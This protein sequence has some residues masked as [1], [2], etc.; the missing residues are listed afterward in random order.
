[1]ISPKEYE[2]Y[3][4]NLFSNVKSKVSAWFGSRVIGCVFVGILTFVMLW[5]FHLEGALTLALFAAVTN[6]IPIAGPLIAGIAMGIFALIESQPIQAVLILVGFILIQQVEGNILTPLLTKKMV[7]I[8]PVLVIVSLLIGARLWGTLG[9]I[10]VI[11]MA[12]ILYEILREFLMK[13]K[14]DSQN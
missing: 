5:A 6:I 8:P 9:A 2:N 7:G 12:G 11:P 14:E 13:K 3:I 1:L 4:C 10:L